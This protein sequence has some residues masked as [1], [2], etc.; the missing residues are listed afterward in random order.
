[1]K[2]RISQ[3]NVLLIG[4]L[5]VATILRFNDINHQPFIDATSWR[6]S[7]TAMMADN[8][9]RKNWN[10]FYPE[11]S[12]NGPEPSYNGRE[13]QLVSYLA[14]LLYTIVGQHDWVGLSVAA[15]FGLWGVF[16]LYQLVLHKFGIK[17]V[18]LLVPQ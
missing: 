12:W 6:Q 4:I 16:A 10:I 13:F 9:Y 17:N 2:I 15:I 8:F 5:I 18:L 7:S 14:A 1:M 3:T 11:I